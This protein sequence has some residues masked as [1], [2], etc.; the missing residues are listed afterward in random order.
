MRSAILLVAG[1]EI[2]ERLRGRAFLVSTVALVAVVL[3]GVILPALQEG[4]ER[5]DVGLAGATPTALAGTL[6]AAADAQEARLVLH[7]YPSVAAGEAAVRD[8]QADVLIVDG[9]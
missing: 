9:A 5:V 3:A 7:R 8:G 4:S 2:T 6:R 1:R